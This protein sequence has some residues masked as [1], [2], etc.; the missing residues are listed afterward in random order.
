A[1]LARLARNADQRCV[2]I[3]VDQTAELRTEHNLRR[4]MLTDSL[5]GL[6]NRAGFSD[7]LE[8]LLDDPASRTDY[9]V[10]VVDLD[11]F[12]RVNACLGS[13]AGD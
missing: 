9:A 1:T 7:R 5:T 12:S 13:M 3:L 6:P 11:R 4:E 10:L 2:L 8:T